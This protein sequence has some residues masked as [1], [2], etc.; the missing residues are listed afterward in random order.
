MREFQLLAELRHPRIIK[1][2]DYGVDSNTPFYTMELLDGSD[3][4]DLAPLPPREACRYLRDTASSLA[5]LHA[6]RLI[7]RDTSP[8][9]VRPTSDGF[10]LAAFVG[11]E[12]PPPELETRITRWS[13]QQNSAGEALVEVAVDQSGTGSAAATHVPVLFRVLKFRSHA[14]GVVVALAEHQNEAAIDIP[15]A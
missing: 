10:R 8:R 6:R 4:R 15:S 13:R 11:D 2:Y 12:D 5:L 3:L 7:H 9:N 1:V 14:D